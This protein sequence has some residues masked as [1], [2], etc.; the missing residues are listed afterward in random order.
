MPTLP[1]ELLIEIFALI[2]TNYDLSLDIMGFIEVESVKES[3][4]N[5]SLASERLKALF[6][7]VKLRLISLDAGYFLTRIPAAKMVIIEDHTL[8]EKSNTKRRATQIGPLQ[9]LAAGISQPD[10]D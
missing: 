4:K 9:I 7:K 1:D 2:P 8:L 10:G 5:V 3:F 6:K